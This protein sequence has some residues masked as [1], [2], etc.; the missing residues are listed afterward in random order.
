MQKK[1]FTTTGNGREESK[2]RGCG[3]SRP[4][5]RFKPGKAY[6]RPGLSALN[7]QSL[8]A[9]SPGLARDGGGR[10]RTLVHHPGVTAQARPKLDCRISRK[11]PSFK[12]LPIA[13]KTRYL[14]RFDDGKQGQ[15]N[16]SD[17]TLW[18]AFYFDWLPGRVA[19]YLAKRHTP[20]ICMPAAGCTLRS[21]PELTMLNVHGVEL[22]MR[23]YVFETAGGLLNVYQCRWEAG[24]GK[25]AYVAQESARYN[26]IRA[27][28]AGRGNHGQ[29]V[30]ELVVSGFVDP[31]DARQALLKEL[32]K[33]IKVDN[34]N[35]PA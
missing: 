18:Q 34:A 15:W 22:P 12:S 27:I 25:E 3:K 20:E 23:S 5:C 2:N 8:R 21:G 35:H 24:V 19:G 29:K 28:W 14:L 13:E 30:L 1:K 31:E 4:E 7:P 26:L 9:W 10:R 11:Q 32:E 6:R 16:E 17:G 33:L